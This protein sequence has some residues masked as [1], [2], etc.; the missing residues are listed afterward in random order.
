M[1]KHFIKIFFRTALKERTYSFINVSGLAVGLASSIF[2]AL[3][4]IDEIGYDKF[5]T[6]RDQIF[7]VMA[8]SSYP[9]GIQ[10]FP[11]TPGPLANALRD[12]PEVEESCRVNDQGGRLLFN[13]GDRSIYEVGVY[14]DEEIFDI[15]TIPLESGDP[16]NPLR[17]NNSIAI[18]E[19]LARKYF[20]QE[21]AIGKVFRLANKF[22]VKVTAVFKDLPRNSTLR[23]EFVLPYEVYAKGD[24]YNNEWGAWTGGSGYVLLHKD[25]NTE[26]LKLKINET[27]TKPR[28]WPRWDDNIDLFLFPMSDWRLYNNFENGKQAG[29]RINYVIAL[30]VAG[31]FILLIACIN[32]MNLATAR[33]MSRSKEVGVRKVIGAARQS[34]VKQFILESVL[35]SM[36]SLV[37]GLLIVHL[38]LP[39]F[40][41]LTE[42]D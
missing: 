37:V 14:A 28:I 7:Q 34:L 1:I 4:I 19:T 39:A 23:F 12:L 40:N 26:A 32:F 10:T 3:W 25:V 8:N 35:I 13:N 42:K 16:A 6:R 29:G 31:A 24:Q 38:L 30:G 22:D 33:S 9:D 18:S 15:F 36:I 41:D 5:H 11:N 17:D 2:I 21:N 27:L 20:D